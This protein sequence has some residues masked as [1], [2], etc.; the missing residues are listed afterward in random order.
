MYGK[1]RFHPDTFEAP[2]LCG[3]L[4][5]LTAPDFI[6]ARFQ[7]CFRNVVLCSPIFEECENF[8]NFAY[9][10]SKFNAFTSN[11]EKFVIH[12]FQYP[13]KSFSFFFD[14][15]IFHIFSQLLLCQ[16]PR[17]LVWQTVKMEYQHLRFYELRNLFRALLNTSDL[18]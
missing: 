7:D 16:S 2:G 15:L 12:S 18:A 6:L 1:R 13:L 4:S 5:P 11:E 10:L 3:V 14:K 8:D 9:I 17:R